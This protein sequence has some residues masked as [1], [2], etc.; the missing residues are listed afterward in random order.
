V[1]ARRPTVI[2]FDVDGTLVRCAGAGRAALCAALS[3]LY[4]TRNEVF[5]SDF[6]FGGRTDR[7]LVR[8]ALAS[9]GV[10][11]AGDDVERAIDAVIARYLTR[12]EETLRAATTYQVLPGVRELLGRIG[13]IGNV[14]VGLGTGNVRPGAFAK[15]ARGGLAEAFSFGGFGCDAEN[16][17]D[18][19]SVGAERGAEKLGVERIACRVVVVGDTPRDVV[20]ARAIGAECL[21][22]AT[23]GSSLGELGAAGATHTVADLAEP[24]A[25][26]ALA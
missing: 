8:E 24:S 18:L 2:L 5:P 22:V 13:G 12:L 19:L 11:G 10:A 23:G 3:D 21:A 26:A 25:F 1:I 6:D 14:A 16:R 20:A 7:A 17:A 9:V 4:E 15:L